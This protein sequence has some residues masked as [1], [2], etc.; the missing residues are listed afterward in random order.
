[1]RKKKTTMS[2]TLTKRK[3]KTPAKKQKATISRLL[4][5]AKKRKIH[6]SVTFR[7][8]RTLRVPKKLKV[9]RQK[10]TGRKRLDNY[11]I[12]RYPLTSEKA[13]KKIEDDN[14][15]VFIVDILANKHQIKEAVKRVYNIRA[16]KI[17]TLIRPR[18]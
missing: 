1:M 13:M 8:P 17:N 10:I 18:R 15:L 4:G 3:S 5:H 7:R 6:T 12:I 11:A 14:T 16:V 9:S 2:K